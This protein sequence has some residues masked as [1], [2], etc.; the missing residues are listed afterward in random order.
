MTSNV[1]KYIAN[2]R[3]NSAHIFCPYIPLIKTIDLAYVRKLSPYEL[4]IK[5]NPIVELLNEM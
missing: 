1:K 3:V 4:R 2:I 5:M